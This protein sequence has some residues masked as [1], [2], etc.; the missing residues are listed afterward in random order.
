[1]GFLTNA[2]INFVA[3]PQV[4]G[5]LLLVDIEIEPV[6]ASA[7]RAISTLQPSASALSPFVLA[8]R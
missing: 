4:I 1:M 2:G 5:S 3:N 8:D 7:H 6:I